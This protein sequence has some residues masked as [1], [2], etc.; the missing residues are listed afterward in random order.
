MG[1]GD[2]GARL[3]G[4]DDAAADT[5]GDGIGDTAAEDAPVISATFPVA[6]AAASADT[7]VPEH[8]T[9][10]PASPPAEA[11]PGGEQALLLATTA[12]AAAAAESAPLPPAAASADRPSSRP[13]SATGGSI[14]APG[15]LEKKRLI[16]PEKEVGLSSDPWPLEGST[17]G[18]ALPR[19]GGGV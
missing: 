7:V 17:G 12:A 13:L 14:S 11:D 4:G 1:H 2:D 9:G 10:D 19:P 5:G 16:I 8:P 3:L 6:A 15:L 18:P